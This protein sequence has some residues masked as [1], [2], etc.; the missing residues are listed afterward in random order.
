LP[1]IPKRVTE[2]PQQSDDNSLS[3]ISPSGLEVTPAS[4]PLS[5]PFTS[6]P[7]RAA[8]RAPEAKADLDALRELANSNARRAIKRSDKRRNSTDLLVNVAVCAFS[9]A[10]GLALLVMNGFRINVT[11]VGMTSAFIVSILWGFDSVRTYLMILR[12]QRDG[13]PTGNDTSE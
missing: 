7:P 2:L 8:N 11:F 3:G 10:C 12:E 1:S 9:L 4:A 13:I 5:R 6:L